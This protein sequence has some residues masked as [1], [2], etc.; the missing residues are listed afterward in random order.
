MWFITCKL[1]KQIQQSILS[2]VSTTK[3]CILSRQWRANVEKF[4]NPKPMVSL[5][6]HHLFASYHQLRLI[7]VKLRC[8]Q[9][10]LRQHKVAL[11]ERKWMNCSISVSYMVMWNLGFHRLCWLWNNY[12]WVIRWIIILNLLISPPRS[13]TNYMNQYTIPFLHGQLICPSSAHWWVWEFPHWL[14]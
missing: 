14:Q 6:T 12:K 4:G 13:E 11:L 9:L 1:E 5:H 8:V 3:S 7:L 2:M 10:C